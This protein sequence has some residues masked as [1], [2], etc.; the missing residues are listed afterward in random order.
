MRS[1]VKIHEASLTRAARDLREATELFGRHTE[2][3]LAVTAGGGRSPWGVGVVSMA[4]DQVNEL[5]GTACRHLHAN[6]HGSG[7]GFQTMADLHATARGSALATVLALDGVVDP[8]TSATRFANSDRVPDSSG[9]VPVEARGAAPA[10]ADQEHGLML[11]PSLETAFAMLGVPWPTQDE[12]RLR[13]CAVAYRACA[14]ALTTEIIPL[15]HHAVGHARVNNAGDAIETAIAFWAGYHHEGD[16]SGHL[17]SLAA[18]LDALADFHDLSAR[19]VAGVKRFLLV[20]AS[21]V[22]AAL[23]WAAMAT[24][25]G[26]GIG[27]LNARAVI[28]GLRG[29]AK[30]FV[31][32]FRRRLEQLLGHAVVRGVQARLRRILAARSPR[33]TATAQRA[34]TPARAGTAAPPDVP[35]ATPPVAQRAAPP[36][37]PDPTPPLTQRPTPPEPPEP[38]PPLPQQAAPPEPREPAPPVAQEPPPPVAVKATPPS[39]GTASPYRFEPT[40][41]PA[42]QYGEER[43]A[44]LRENMQRDG[45]V[46][47]PIFVVHH[48]GR[49]FVVDGNHRLRASEGVLDEIPFKEVQLP[50]L[51]YRHMR[52]VLE[53]WDMNKRMLPDWMR[54]RGAHGPGDG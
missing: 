31:T 39:A 16:D 33:A 17:S 53:G 13:A 10:T 19:F 4:M 30:R 8:A 1:G 25:L 21:L 2:T 48:E 9:R 34:A 3:L 5:L 7:A 35:T 15:A 41:P 6:L 44:R 26:G 49:M 38:T 27:A 28:A 46:G 42:G 24:V 54:E 50:F 29:I 51:G 23:V 52:D 47:R 36:E 12:G 37:P 43:V 11:P 40:D 22:A 32:A 20:L 45:W 18:A 14:G